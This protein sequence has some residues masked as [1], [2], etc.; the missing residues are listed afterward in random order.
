ML[1]I[2]LPFEGPELLP[3]WLFRPASG[4]EPP[5]AGVPAPPP[6]TSAPAICL[7]SSIVVASDITAGGLM[8]SQGPIVATEGEVPPT[9]GQLP[10]PCPILLSMGQGQRKALCVLTMSQVSHAAEGGDSKRLRIPEPATVPC[11]ASRPGSRPCC[12]HQSLSPC[13]THVGPQQ[14]RQ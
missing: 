5:P 9:R 14:V 10:T 1:V 12:H 3:G 8:M 11:G 4:T 7:G 13:W 2:C 6:P